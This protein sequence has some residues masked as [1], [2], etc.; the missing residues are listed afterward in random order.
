MPEITYGKAR[1]L[2][3]NEATSRR[4]A[5]HGVS[6]TAAILLWLM[7]DGKVTPADIEIAMPEP[8]FTAEPLRAG[9]VGDEL[10]QTPVLTPVRC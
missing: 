3:V 5:A 7:M 8:A 10:R 9:L 4:W 1:L 6:G 2:G